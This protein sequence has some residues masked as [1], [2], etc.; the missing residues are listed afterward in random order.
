MFTCD[1]GNYGSGVYAIQYF[2]LLEDGTKIIEKS[3]PIEV[4]V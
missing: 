2:V 4:T 1:I 3:N